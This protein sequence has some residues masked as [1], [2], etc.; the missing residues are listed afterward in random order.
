MQAWILTNQYLIVSL[1]LVRSGIE[2]EVLTD[3]YLKIF[4]EYSFSHR[5][6][7]LIYEV[8]T[9]LH[10]WINLHCLMFEYESEKNKIMDFIDFTKVSYS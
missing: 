10:Y 6:I 4:E 5:K 2:Y 9:I 3:I 7:T 8:G 1:I